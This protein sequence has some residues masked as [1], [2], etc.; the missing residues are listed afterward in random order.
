MFNF[1]QTLPKLGTI[2]GFRLEKVIISH[3]FCFEQSHPHALR[4]LIDFPN[5]F[6]HEAFIHHLCVDDPKATKTLW[7][8]HNIPSNHMILKIILAPL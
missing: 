1:M 5:P 8:T 4:L 6:S 2:C 7:S 3:I